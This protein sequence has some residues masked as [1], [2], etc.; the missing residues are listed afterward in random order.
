[1]ILKNIR[2]KLLS[3]VVNIGKYCLSN[4]TSL[5]GKFTPFEEKVAGIIFLDFS[6]AFDTVPHVILLDKQSNY[7]INR[8]TLC[9][10]L[11]CLDIRAQRIVLNGATSGWRPV[12]SGVSQ[13]SILGLVLFNI[14]ISDLDTR[15]EC[16]LNKFAYD[17]KL[18]V[19]IDSLE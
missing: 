6:K 19:P 2:I 18:G 1:M 5:Y 12:T 3:D 10:V 8:F 7:K 4:L 9:W 16:I 11:S 15:V 13:S 17:A 14:F